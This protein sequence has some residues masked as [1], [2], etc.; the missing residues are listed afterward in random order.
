[1]T[2]TLLDDEDYNGDDD[3]DDNDDNDDDDDNNDDDNDD[4]DNDDVDDLVDYILASIHEGK[5]TLGEKRQLAKPHLKLLLSFDFVFMNKSL[6][7]LSFSFDFI[8]MNKYLFELSFS[9]HFIFMNESLNF[10][11]IFVL[12]FIMAF[13]LY[14]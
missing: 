2:N 1:M 4:N 6:F 9:F 5:G 7:E 10:F 13:I 11:F 12:D 8:F 3:D 14:S